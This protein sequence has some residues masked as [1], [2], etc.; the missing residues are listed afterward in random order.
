[1][2]WAKA[3]VPLSHRAAKQDRLCQLTQCTLFICVFGDSI[4][5]FHDKWSR[6][7]FKHSTVDFKGEQTGLL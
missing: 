7:K 3:I 1:M 4:G 2:L 6:F 5:S